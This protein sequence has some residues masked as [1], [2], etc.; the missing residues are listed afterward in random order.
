MF[1]RLFCALALSVTS[2]H[3]A[4]VNTYAGKVDVAENPAKVAVFDIAALDTLTALG[5]SLSGVPEN[6][7]VDY[8]DHATKGVATVGNLFEPDFEA[9]NA[10]AP[11]LVVVGGR[12]SKQ[13]KAM[14]EMA[15][16]IDMTI[17]ED[18]V[19]QGL[20][21]LDAFGTIFGKGAEADALKAAFTDK[22]AHT[23]AALDGKGTAL[24]VMTN[25][26]KI[27]AYGAGGRF[28]WLHTKLGLEEAVEGVEHSSHG[29]AISFEFIKEANPDILIVIDRLAAIGRPGESAATTL[30]N[31]LVA[32][33]TA[34][35]KGDVVYL[36]AADIYIAGGGIQSMSRTLDAF[37]SAFSSS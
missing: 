37:L 3:A 24:I 18:T 28:D 12:S 10:M 6:I 2:L 21:R 35:K 11:D 30:D 14:S 15:P 23:K 36:N 1:K 9:V 19:G 29:E 8:L 34:W 7:Y 5:V 17:W 13:L 31:P 20:E 33:T 22:L 25:G 4:E 27:S 26:P 32:E 16:T